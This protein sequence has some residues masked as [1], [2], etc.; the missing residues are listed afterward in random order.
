MAFLLLVARE[1]PGL[2]EPFVTSVTLKTL[3]VSVDELM[4]FQVFFF[5]EH[6]VT[7]SAGM[8]SALVF[9]LMTLLTESLATLAANKWPHF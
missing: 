5:F 3:F 8:F 4:R 2:F 7:Q 1:V 6:F 9:L